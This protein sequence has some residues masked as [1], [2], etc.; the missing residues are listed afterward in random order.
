[1]AIM[2]QGKA[3]VEYSRFLVCVCVCVSTHAYTHMQTVNRKCCCKITVNIRLPACSLMPVVKSNTASLYF[4]FIS[5]G[6][7]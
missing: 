1:M 6:N 4:E 3:A 7:P 5:L 2:D